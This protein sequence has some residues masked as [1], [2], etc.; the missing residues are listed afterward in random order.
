MK[1]LN[2]ADRR[3]IRGSDSVEESGGWMGLI[4]DA[5]EKVGGPNGI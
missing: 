2:Q 4:R 3:I 1:P 5:L